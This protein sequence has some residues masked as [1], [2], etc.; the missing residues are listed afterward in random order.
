M[1]RKSLKSP[2]VLALAAALALAACGS[3]SSSTSSSSES[4][5]EATA[6]TEAAST[7][8]VETTEVETTE[9]EAEPAPAATEV[10]ITHYSGTDVVPVNPQTVVVMDTGVYLSMHELGIEAAGFGSL[11]VPVPA[12]FDAILNDPDLVN[13]GTAFEPDYEAINALEPDLIIVA[14]RSSATYAEMSKIAPTVDLTFGDGVDFTTAFT[15][16][17]MALGQIFSLEDE[18]VEELLAL[19]AEVDALGVEVA[20]AGTALILLT[21]GDEITAFGPGSRFGLVH[22]VFG[23]APADDSLDPEAGHGDTVSFEFIAEAAPDALFVI[24]RAAAIGQDGEGAA[25]VLD[26]ELVASTPAWTNDRVVYVDGFS[27]YIAGGSIPATRSI[28]E[29]IKSSLPG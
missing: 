22:D 17:H 25:A 20:G 19:S 15:D 11:G 18:V 7:T 23:Y 16:R 26:N 28:I 14:S 21:N 29:D 24:D 27:W 8:E 12:E 1:M 6:T 10:E 2:L 9:A 13:V 3:G 5:S 4:D